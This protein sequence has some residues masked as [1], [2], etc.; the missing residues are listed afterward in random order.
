MAGAAPLR[1]LE[2]VHEVQLAPRS[3]GGPWHGPEMPGAF[4]EDFDT[5][6]R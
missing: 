5:T 6:S 3:P 4:L 2:A 1:L